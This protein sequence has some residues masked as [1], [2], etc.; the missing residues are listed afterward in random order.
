[1]DA[2]TWTVITGAIVTILTML[3]G[4]IGALWRWVT[5]LREEH[6]S[7]LKQIGELQAQVAELKARL[8]AAD[9]VRA[10]ADRLRGERDQLA[11]RVRSLERRVLQLGGE[12][13]EPADDAV[14]VQ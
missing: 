12:I 5:G 14:S 2:A 13:T 3:A 6:L 1:M 7:A 8:D 9:E 10:L 4:G 11:R